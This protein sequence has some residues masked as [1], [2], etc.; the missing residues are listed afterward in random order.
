M[1]TCDNCN[2][3]SDPFTDWPTCT[4]CALNVCDYCQVDN[5]YHEDEG[6]AYCYCQVCEEQD[7]NMVAAEPNE[8]WEPEPKEDVSDVDFG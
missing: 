7:L 4:G 5:S 8:V 3:R 2:R 1:A 6:G